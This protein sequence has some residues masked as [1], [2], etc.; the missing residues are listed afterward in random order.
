MGS[1]LCLSARSAQER[2]RE[3]ER[4][5]LWESQ[6]YTSVE[7]ISLSLD[8]LQPCVTGVGQ[9]EAMAITVHE[10]VGELSRGGVKWKYGRIEVDAVGS[11]G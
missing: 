10:E 3:R 11:A 1:A 5:M 6:A 2:E 7:Q 8:A 4:E 9:I